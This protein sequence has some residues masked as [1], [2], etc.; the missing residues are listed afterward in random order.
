MRIDM[1]CHVSGNGRD[2]QNLNHD[3][4][5]N[6][7]D[8]QHWF[9]RLLYALIEN[10]LKH[11]EADLNR[12]GNISTDEYFKLLYKLLKNSEELDGIVLLALDGVY[13]GQTGE[14][15]P[16]KTDLLISN[17]FLAERVRQL[18]AQLEQ[19]GILK[20]F[21]LGASVNPNRK[22]WDSELEFVITQTEAVL[23]KLIPST[24]GIDLADK[25]H[26][27]F[28]QQ[29]AKA[30]LP[31]L[32]HV[33]P[34][35][36][37]PEG[38][39]QPALDDYRKLT[40]P[41]EQGVT[42]IA[43]HCAAPVFPLVDKNTIKDFYAFMKAANGGGKVQLWGDTSAFSISTR[44]PFIGEMVD[45]FPP[46]WLVNGSDFP[47]PIEAWPHLPW[48]THDMSRE[49]FVKISQ[50]KNILDRDVRLKRAHG[51]AEAILENAAQV[52]RL[53]NGAR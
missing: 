7:E 18:N 23:L 35:Y 40:K 20:G 34:E 39:R 15:D 27:A 21:Y 44:I 24:Q 16:V 53:P 19:E 3:V 14:L 51:F 11:L 22:D 30:N 50:T 2:L 26:E 43:A 41:L 28:Y 4:Y 42:I 29:L 38:I 10:D 49:E 12:D 52:L 36:S 33:G 17:R 6:A 37:F 13:A 47:V 5:F 48:V 1:H 25:R 31:L 8:N 46:E 9:T 32:C 45:T